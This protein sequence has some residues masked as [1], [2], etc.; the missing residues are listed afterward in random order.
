MRG[1]ALFALTVL[2][3]ASCVFATPTESLL[4]AADQLPPANF[5]ISPVT[6]YDK[7]TDLV[8]A[9][10]G[11]ASVVVYFN[12]NC[13]HC[14]LFAPQFIEAAQHY[15]SEKKSLIAQKSTIKQVPM[16]EEALAAKKKRVLSQ[17]YANAPVMLETEEQAAPLQFAALDAQLHPHLA[18]GFMFKYF[19]GVFYVSPSGEKTLYTGS[20]D[21]FSVLKW[22]RE[23]QGRDSSPAAAYLDLG[24]EAEKP[25]LVGCPVNQE[26]LLS[27]EE[28]VAEEAAD[29]ETQ[30]D[31]Q[32]AE[33][34]A[35]DPNE[36]DAFLSKLD[37]TVDT[38][39]GWLANESDLNARDHELEVLSADQAAQKQKAADAKRVADE[40]AAAASAQVSEAKNDQQ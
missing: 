25:E 3:A 12:A 16:S 37:A 33:Q 34:E 5:G 20:R 10:S 26:S 7:N 4:E 17:E 23:T 13:H 2:V 11:K 29:A 31:H 24:A 15:F 36:V 22:I 39:E 6:V 21:S 18:S 38:F 28:I 27:V 19:P 35:A 1:V 30:E 40:K 9:I 14:K 8:N 32:V